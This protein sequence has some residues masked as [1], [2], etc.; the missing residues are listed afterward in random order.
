MYIIILG[1]FLDAITCKAGSAVNI[2]SKYTRHAQYIALKTR[3][4]LI[5]KN[6]VHLSSII[7]H[8]V[9]IIIGF[10][11]FYVENYAS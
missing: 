2:C 7:G 10:I 3:A 1:T 9:F 4:L 11:R 6:P 5:Q 8:N